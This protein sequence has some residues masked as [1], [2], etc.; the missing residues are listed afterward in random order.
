[1]LELPAFNLL[2]PTLFTVDST[3]KTSWLRGRETLR[4]NLFQET[5]SFEM[6]C[7]GSLVLRFNLSRLPLFNNH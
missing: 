1:M 4:G 5:A 6:Q 7:K 3:D 2:L